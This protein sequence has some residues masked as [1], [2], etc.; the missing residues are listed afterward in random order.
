MSSSCST[1]GSLV[2]TS[3]GIRGVRQPSLLL[4]VRQGQGRGVAAKPAMLRTTAEG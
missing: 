3:A 2:C 4:H 1:P